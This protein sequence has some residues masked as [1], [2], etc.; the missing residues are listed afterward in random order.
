M[1]QLGRN[2]FKGMSLK[3]SITENEKKVFW[4]KRDSAETIKFHVNVKKVPKCTN[5]EL[6]AEPLQIFKVF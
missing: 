3:L 6:D 4:R 1:R 2:I 5:D